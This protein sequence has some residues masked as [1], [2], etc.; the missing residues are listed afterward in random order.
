MFNLRQNILTQTKES[1]NT[2]QCFSATNIISALVLQCII[3]LQ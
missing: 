1:S 3:L 2:I